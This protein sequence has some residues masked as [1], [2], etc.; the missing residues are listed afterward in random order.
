ML[1]QKYA[2]YLFETLKG[3]D[4]G[5]ERC[6]QAARELMTQ[7]TLAFH[8][9]DVPAQEEANNN[10]DGNRT[11]LLGVNISRSECGEEG[12]CEETLPDQGV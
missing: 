5:S 11:N 2:F 12:I 4:M 10:V 6:R 8:L 7:A 9:D 3:Y 1:V